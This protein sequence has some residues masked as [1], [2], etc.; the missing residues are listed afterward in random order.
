MNHNDAHSAEND[1]TIDV[2][3]LRDDALADMF[4][5]FFVRGGV[6]CEGR[7]DGD[8]APFGTFVEC[9]E[10]FIEDGRSNGEESGVGSCG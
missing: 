2:L 5:F 10:E 3:K 9:D 7:Q 1:R 6:A 4:R 8:T